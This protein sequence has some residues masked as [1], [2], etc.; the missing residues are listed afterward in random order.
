[1]QAE[2]LTPLDDGRVRLGTI[3]NP[4]LGFHTVV[5]LLAVLGLMEVELLRRPYAYLL[6]KSSGGLDVRLRKTA[7]VHVH[8]VQ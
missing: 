6:L 2:L 5:S 4:T 7:G 8:V 1:M 3:T